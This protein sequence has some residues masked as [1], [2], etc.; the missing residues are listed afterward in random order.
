MKLSNAI[1]IN[2]LSIFLLSQEAHAKRWEFIHQSNKN[3][4]RAYFDPSS[5][6]RS[7]FGITKLWIKLEAMEGGQARIKTGLVESR[8]LREFD[9]RNKKQR[10][11]YTWQDQ[12]G[13]TPVST[14]YQNAIFE[15]IAPET[16][17]ERIINKVCA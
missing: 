9:C 3:G 17:D 11:L 6:S 4:I 7:I 10:I 12:F 15:Y 5:K 2:L 14:N 16:V 8:E 13:R 1:V